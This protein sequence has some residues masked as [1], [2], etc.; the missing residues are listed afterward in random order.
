MEKWITALISIGF[1]IITM[2][3]SSGTVNYLIL[4]EGVIVVVTGCVLLL[5]VKS[6]NKDVKKDNKKMGGKK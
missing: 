1:L 3:F 2:S 6:K 4:I 5:R